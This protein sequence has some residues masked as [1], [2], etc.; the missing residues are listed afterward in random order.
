MSLVV[1]EE[2]TV[3][4]EQNVRAFLDTPRG[5]GT[6]RVLCTLA[7][8]PALLGEGHQGALRVGAGGLCMP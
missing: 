3:Y 5:R 8:T 7:L 6:E 4:R 2:M 1:L